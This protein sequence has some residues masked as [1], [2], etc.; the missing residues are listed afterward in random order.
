MNNK[1]TRTTVNMDADA[2]SYRLGFTDEEL[3]FVH[4]YTN[5][6]ERMVHGLGK[7][8][9]AVWRLLFHDANGYQHYMHSRELPLDSYVV[10]PLCQIPS[11]VTETKR[12][13]LDITVKPDE[14]NGKAIREAAIRSL[15]M[16]D[17]DE[18]KKLV[19]KTR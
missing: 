8:Y 6:L 7:P 19:K 4:N 12:M 14:D 5:V 17:D 3:I 9:Q 11:G 13:K 1:Q 18:I 15:L 2:L 16:L 10:V